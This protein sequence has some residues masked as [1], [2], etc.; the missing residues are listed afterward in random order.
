MS[1]QYTSD[2][3]GAPRPWDLMLRFRNPRLEADY[4]ASQ[5]LGLRMSMDL[6]VLFMGIVLALG[7]WLRAV[8]EGRVLRPLAHLEALVVVALRVGIFLVALKRQQLYLS[9]RFFF[10]S[11]M[12]LHTLV[13]SSRL[14]ALFV[15][16]EATPWLVSKQLVWK[17]SVTSMALFP[18][19]FQL[20]FRDHI[21]IHL[22]CCLTALL[23]TSD[24][25]CRSWLGMHLNGDQFSSAF[26][27]IGQNIETLIYQVTSFTISKSTKFVLNG[28]DVLATA[29]PS[30]QV[31]A[32]SCWLIIS[33]CHI[34]GGFVIPSAMLYCLEGYNRTRFLMTRALDDQQRRAYAWMCLETMVIMTWICIITVM[35]AWVGLHG[36]EQVWRGAGSILGIL[37]DGLFN[38]D[39]HNSW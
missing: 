13:Y 4:W 39:T 12:R 28:G 8:R 36:M 19:G 1:A 30:Q 7:M 38:C 21:Q 10:V 23:W 34:A 11:S 37:D 16:A 26:T 17:S 22:I 20:P 15:P 33:F 5:S 2:G 9:N 27:S 24:L 25:Y 3:I 14:L 18:F 32:H 35:G 31:S 29:L 6:M